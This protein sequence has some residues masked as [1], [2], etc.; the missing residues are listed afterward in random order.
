MSFSGE[1]KGPRSIRMKLYNGL[2]LIMKIFRRWNTVN[3][4]RSLM[5]K[6]PHKT[7]IKTYC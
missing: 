5:K 7:G 4:F 3:M 1:L 2:L 6:Y